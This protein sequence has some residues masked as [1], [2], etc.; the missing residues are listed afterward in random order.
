[1]KLE[2][3]KEYRLAQHIEN[4]INSSLFDGQM[5]AESLRYFHPTLQQKFYR[6]IKTCISELAKN[7]RPIDDRN[8]A[9]FEEC[10]KLHEF[11]KTEGKGIP[12]I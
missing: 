2:E 11:L 4:E 3:T 8:K 1:M 10:R 7:D 12:T 5:F 9:S 6:V